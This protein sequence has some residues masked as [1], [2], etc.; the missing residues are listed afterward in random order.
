[1]G[2]Y[3]GQKSISF[4]L[5]ALVVSLVTFLILQVLPGDP[6]RLILGTEGSPQAYARLR[7]ELRLDQPAGERYLQWL[8]AFG[9]GRWGTSLRY[10]LGVRELVGQALP[11]T[12]T[13]AV[14]AVGS[15]LAAA[16]PAGIYIAVRPGNWGAKGLSFLVQIGMALP[17]FWVGILLIQFLAVRHRLLPAGG[18][19]GPLAFV[20]PVL[21]LA[22]PR[23]AVLTRQV[24]AGTKEALTQDY[25]RTARAKGL[26]ERVVLFKHA[27]L[28]GVFGVLTV[29]G[30]QLAQLFAGTIVVEQVFGLPGL[31]QLLLA[32]VFQRDLPLVQ[33]IVMVVAVLILLLNW[34]HDLLLALLDPRLRYD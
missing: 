25:V 4:I 14:L 6:A 31:G 18:R 15:A 3:L 29:A 10:G 16:I 24:R 22:L 30:I 20:L 2:R 1:M 17:Q 33:G 28:N 9:Y 26:P 23:A 7:E 34:I 8:F 12:L 27:F 19:E 11:L 21:T 32:G 13:I 5:T